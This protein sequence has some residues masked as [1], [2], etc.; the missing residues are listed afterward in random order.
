MH[1]I[2][3]VLLMI[4]TLVACSSNA[5]RTSE[6]A[7]VANP[8][9]VQMPNS[10]YDKQSFMEFAL[11][12]FEKEEFVEARKKCDTYNV[13]TQ[14]NAFLDC[15]ERQAKENPDSPEAQYLLGVGYV[16]AGKKAETWK[17]YEI[18]RSMSVNF[19]KLLLDVIAHVRPELLKQK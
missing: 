16:Y 17:Q 6:Y 18:L 9:S 11:T 12:I 13:D 1:T 2:L 8:N 5:N 7:P 19:S 3:V 4:T 10:P 15:Q 14:T